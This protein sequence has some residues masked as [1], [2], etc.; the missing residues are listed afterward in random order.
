MADR[1]EAVCVGRRGTAGTARAEGPFAALAVKRACV[2]GA[3]HVGRPVRIVSLDRDPFHRVRFLNAAPRSRGRGVESSLLPVLRGTVDELPEALDALIVTSDLQ[4]VVP[5]T[6]RGGANALLGEELAYELAGLAEDRELPER[7]ATGVLLA[8]DLYSAP[9]GNVR[10]AS[11]DVREVWKAF[12]ECFRWVAGVAGNH[13]F[14]GTESEQ[15]RFA[16]RHALLDGEVRT[17]DELRVGGVGYIM[18]RSAKPG[19]VEEHDFLASLE[20]V[21]EQRPDVLVL[22][23][24][25]NGASDQRGDALVRDR[26]ERSGPG[27]VVCG[28]VHWDEPL[29]EL[30]SSQVLNVDARALVLTR[31]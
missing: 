14:F 30:G 1:P 16:S 18:G 19:R 2:R 15:R 25:P 8:G 21:C 22:H 13:D 24:G 9:G 17:I 10:G 27:L 5:S 4:G 26:I 6:A 12:D 7:D 23:Q 20:L 11:G 31:A 29:A 3:S 28:H